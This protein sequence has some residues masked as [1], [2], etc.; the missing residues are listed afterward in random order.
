MLGLVLILVFISRFTIEF[1]K[2]DQT[3]FEEGMFFD[4]SS[5]YNAGRGDVLNQKFQVVEIGLES[6][7]L[8]FVGFPDEP[9][10]RLAIGG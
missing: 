7:D 5:I 1:S 2:I 3:Y 4:G 6:V 8:G 9:P 10:A